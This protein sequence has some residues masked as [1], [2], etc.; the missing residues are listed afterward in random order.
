MK[1]KI[2][3]LIVS[4]IMLSCILPIS[5]SAQSTIFGWPADG[6]L[7]SGFG[8]RG[9]KMHYGI[10]I[11][12]SG[13]V[14][15]FST[16]NGVVSRSDYSSTYGH[17]VYVEH[18]IY[19]Q[20]VETVYAHLK[21]RHVSVGN[22]VNKGTRL[23][24]MG[25]TGDSDGQHLHFE[26]HFGKWNWNKT[27][28]VDPLKVLNGDYDN[29]F[30]YDDPSNNPTNGSYGV[31]RVDYPSGHA[32][33]TSS[34]PNGGYKSKVYGGETYKVYNYQ[35]G[36]HDIGNNTWIHDSFVEFK[37]YT[38]Y[39]N[40]PSNYGVNTYNSPGGS[41]KSKIYG[42]ETY[43]VYD[44]S[45]GYY[46]IGNST[47]VPKE[48]VII[49]IP[50]FEGSADKSTE[51]NNNPKN[52]SYGYIKLNYDQD[53]GVNTYNAPNGSY[54]GKTPGGTIYS[55]YDY[56]DGYYDIGA[57][58]WVSESTGNFKPFYAKI[59]NSASTIN[60]Y[61]APYGEIKGNIESN[62]NYRVYDYKDGFFEIGG[63]Q[64]LNNSDVIIVKPTF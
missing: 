6:N 28:A 43:N 40:F 34:S 10:D 53:Y 22:K 4:L 13:T 38:A 41:Y 62:S 9:G 23:G 14:P 44:Y 42:G 25:N 12:K 45:D 8:M 59:N 27:N 51:F 48:H 61:S 30:N 49:N 24:L 32:I 55:V 36:Y 64:W 21:E 57:S 37:R 31:L 7:S 26:V 56:K 47:W 54:K 33:N 5:L 39:V 52:G 16:Y 17:V 46:D 3:S 60:T 50:T 20:T 15:V 2:V 18:S 58:T 35:E 1:N 63:A 11:S 19:G 29:I